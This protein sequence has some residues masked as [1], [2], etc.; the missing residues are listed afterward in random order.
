MSTCPGQPREE[1]RLWWVEPMGGAS[2]CL[3]GTRTSALLTS[4]AG[5]P[6]PARLLQPSHPLQRCRPEDGAADAT[7]DAEPFPD[8]E[9]HVPSPDARFAGQTE[10]SITI[11]SQG[12]GPG[13]PVQ[14]SPWASSPTAEEDM[15]SGREQGHRPSPTAQPQLHHP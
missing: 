14:A 15:A 8:L 7:S 2:R 6:H 1:Q 3:A 12:G 10:R 11:A 5:Q 4:H 9:R 13:S